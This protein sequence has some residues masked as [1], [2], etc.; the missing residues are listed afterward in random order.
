MRR[1]GWHATSVTDRLS[2]GPEVL[3][4]QGFLFV[5]QGVEDRR[6]RGLVRR[7]AGPFAG[8]LG[9]RLLPGV[10]PA[11]LQTLGVAPRTLP[12]TPV[13]LPTDLSAQP[14]GQRREL[15][16]RHARAFGDPGTVLPGRLRAAYEATE[17][18]RAVWDVSACESPAAQVIVRTM[19]SK[20]G[21]SRRGWAR[22]RGTACRAR[23][24]TWG[25]RDWRTCASDGCGRCAWRG[26]RAAFIAVLLHGWDGGWPLHAIWRGTAMISPPKPRARSR[27][28]PAQGRQLGLIQGIRRY[29]RC[30]PPGRSFGKA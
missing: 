3:F 23:L 16:H 5:G 6:S 4:E 24:P 1:L 21:R 15:A 9:T 29:R 8:C 26:S 10:R 13:Q 17:D 18:P 28:N 7:A 12:R 20:G 11:S 22:C 27:R 2:C 19:T 14:C 25:V 30:M